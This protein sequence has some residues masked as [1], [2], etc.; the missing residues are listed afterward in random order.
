VELH[1]EERAE[2]ASAT[3]PSEKAVAHGVSQ[4]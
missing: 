1:A 3:T 2:R 4:A